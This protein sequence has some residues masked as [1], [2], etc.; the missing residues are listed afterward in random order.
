MSD[1]NTAM[2]S[3]ARRDQH[4]LSWSAA[5]Q[6]IRN[7]ARAAIGDLTKKDARQLY[8]LE[9]SASRHAGPSPDD[10]LTEA[11]KVLQ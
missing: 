6:E 9:L 8:Q 7:L 11:R 10:L 3:A 5:E 2:S 1:S 4:G